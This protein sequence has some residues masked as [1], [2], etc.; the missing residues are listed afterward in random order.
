[1]QEALAFAPTLEIQHSHLVTMRNNVEKLPLDYA[2]YLA[3]I[4]QLKEAIENLERARGLLWSEMRGLRTSI[5]YLHRVDPL[6]QDNLQP[7]MKIS[8][9]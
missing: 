8:R 3:D 6:W 4:G 2:S 5:D 9:H 7:S 1:M